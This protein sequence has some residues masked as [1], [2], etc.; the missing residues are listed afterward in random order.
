MAGFHKR[1][2]RYRQ[3]IERAFW[4]IDYLLKEAELIDIICIEAEEKIECEI[5]KAISHICGMRVVAEK[6]GASDCKC[7]THLFYFEGTLEELR[8]ELRKVETARK[9]VGC[10]E[11]GNTR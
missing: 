8:R 11:R 7:R 3:G 6:F 9:S 10:F 1:L 2:P 4:H 5:A